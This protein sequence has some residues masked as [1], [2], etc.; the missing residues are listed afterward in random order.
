MKKEE[1]KNYKQRFMNGFKMLIHTKSPY[2]VWD[3]L[4]L[5]YA[6]E[7]ANTTLRQL[8]ENE[9]FR[10]VWEEREKQYIETIK[11]YTK[12]EQKIISQMFTML[13][14]E[15]EE[16]PNQDLLGELYMCLEISNKNNG[17]FFTPY[18]VCEVMSKVTID[19]KNLTRQIKQNG[20]ITI[21][22]CACG[23]GAT[24]ISATEQC[25]DMF[26]R[27]NYQNHIMV[28][29]Q[30]IDI[31]CVRMCYIQIS[32][33]GMAGYVICGNTLTEPF[34]TDLHR[35]W[36]TPIWFSDVWTMRRLFHNQNILGNEVKE[37]HE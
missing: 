13:V 28:V 32:L 10:S 18:S 37:E 29:G 33:H 6:I 23:A 34:I 9:P 4:M 5:L 16:R 25:K 26:K 3:D 19:R 2:K 35:I 30:D 27:L 31:T 22:D 1:N 14:L 24:L 11:T 12:K 7:I 36:F 21:N 20:Y 15:L 8:K 17:Q